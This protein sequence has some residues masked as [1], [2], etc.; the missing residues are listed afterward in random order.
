MMW[1][2]LLSIAFSLIGVPALLVGASSPPSSE[3][4]AQLLA[5]IQN[6]HDPVRKSKE[7]TRLARIKLRQ[8]IQAYEQGNMDQGAQLLSAYLGWIKDSWQI[9][10]SSGRN[11]ARASQG[12]KELDIELREDERL[13]DD[14]ERRVSYFERGP[15]EKAKKEVEQVRAEVL[16]ALFPAA[17]APEAAKPLRKTD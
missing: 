14:L 15:I 17:Q 7:E 9:L 8:V 3:T 10:R 4:E 13:L 11:A 12:F 5:R 1:R 6:E 16:Q 2:A